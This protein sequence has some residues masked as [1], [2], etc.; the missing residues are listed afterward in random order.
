MAHVGGLLPKA[1][2]IYL[3]LPHLRIV[4]L[5]RPKGTAACVPTFAYMP[6]IISSHGKTRREVCLRRQCGFRLAFLRTGRTEL[7]RRAPAVL[8]RCDHTGSGRRR[9][10][11]LRSR[12]GSP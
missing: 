5:A 8:T 6:R 2:E 12:S 9:L 10:A 11:E 3:P 7:G 4:D 1:V